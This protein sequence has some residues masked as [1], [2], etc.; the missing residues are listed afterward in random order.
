MTVHKNDD[1]DDDDADK[2][3][4]G[5]TYPRRQRMSQVNKEFCRGEEI[6]DGLWKGKI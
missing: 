2:Q 4:K 3:W 6:S 1:D 5:F